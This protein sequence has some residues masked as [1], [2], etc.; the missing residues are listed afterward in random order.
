MD[1]QK[2]AV[3][4]STLHHEAVPVPLNSVHALARL[5]IQVCEGTN[6]PATLLCQYS[7]M[8]F[9]CAPAISRIFR[10]AAIRTKIA[11]KGFA[12][13][14]IG[15]HSL[16]PSGAM[17]LF[18]NDVDPKLIRKLGRWQSDTWL[19]Y[20]HNQI[21]ELTQ[22]LSRKIVRPIVFHNVA[23]ARTAVTAECT[24]ILPLRLHG[25]GEHPVGDVYRHE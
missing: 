23:A 8:S 15:T 1:N 19:T 14:R 12:I 25:K 24:S 11:D 2:N 10:R 9:V 17:S 22:G 4:D 20:I 7:P 16:R 18:L 6:S 5:F 3:W 21:A 13:D